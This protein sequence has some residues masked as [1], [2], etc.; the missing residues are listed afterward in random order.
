MHKIDFYKNNLDIGFM[1]IMKMFNFSNILGPKK[2]VE[3]TQNHEKCPKWPIF[4]HVSQFFDMFSRFLQGML[5]IKI[6]EITCSF[7]IWGSGGHIRPYT[8]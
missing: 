2:S 6:R 7:R 3:F 1:K 5:Y 4:Q 8:R